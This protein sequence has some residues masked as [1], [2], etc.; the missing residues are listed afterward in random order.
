M[1]QPNKNTIFQK[2]FGDTRIPQNRRLA[3]SISYD[4]NLLDFLTDLLSLEREHHIGRP[5]E[6]TD[7]PLPAHATFTV[8]QADKLLLHFMS[9]Y[10][11]NLIALAHAIQLHFLCPYYNLQS[12]CCPAFFRTT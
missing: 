10:G 12:I 11:T 6:I 3:I 5:L 1:H 9:A 4:R 8:L 2:P 7:I